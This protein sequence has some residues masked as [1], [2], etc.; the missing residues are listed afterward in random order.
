MRSGGGCQVLELWA[1]NVLTAVLGVLPPLARSR[2]NCAVGI[3]DMQEGLLESRT[4]LVDSSRMQLQGS[5]YA[6]LDGRRLRFELVPRPKHGLG[7]SVVT[8][9]VVE[10][11]L[12]DFR[13]QF[14]PE[15]RL[16]TVLGQARS[17]VRAF[18]ERLLRRSL[19]TDG[20]ALCEE[21]LR[22]AAAAAVPNDSSP[23]RP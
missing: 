10:G 17:V 13:A 8:P 23:A 14:K 18:A 4:I 3:F 12:R 15:L 19:P 21:L 16:R 22:Q 6:D 20:S 11:T 1:V 9:V 5:G 2:L 7:A